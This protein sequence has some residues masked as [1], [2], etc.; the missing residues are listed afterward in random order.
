MHRNS[1]AD[2]ATCNET[3]RNV[4]QKSQTFAQA[5]CL[6]TNKSDLGLQWTKYLRLLVLDKG[7]LIVRSGRKAENDS[8]TS[9]CE[10]AEGMVVAFT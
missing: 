2:V 9:G 5:Q 4:R 8:E 6:T 1:A 10:A 7:K 3:R